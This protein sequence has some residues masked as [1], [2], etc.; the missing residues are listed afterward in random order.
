MGSV[1]ALAGQVGGAK[2]ADGLYRLRQDRLTVVVNTGDDYEHLGLAFSPDLDTMLYTL[3]GMASAVAPWE[4][5]SE[6]HAVHAM[7][8]ALGGPDRPIHGDRSLAAP[9]LR[10]Q[11]LASERSLSQITAA[12]CRNLGIAARVVP[13]SDDRVR[14][15]VETDE[16]NVT[17]QE[18]F[19]ELSCEPA[20]RGFQYAGAEDA[21]MPDA[22]LDALH[23]PDLEAIVICPANPY[24]AIQPILQVSGMKDLL[25]QRRVPVVAVT[26]IVGGRALKGSAGKI[27]RELGREPSARA[28]A[29]QYL[30]LIDGFVL[31]TEDSA[32]VESVRSLGME[33]VALPTIMRTLDDR[34]ALAHEVLDFAANIRVRREAEVE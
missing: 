4:P 25:K 18:Y 24:H 2:L 5:E 10:A 33:V 16:G 17:F 29:A 19:H 31:D 23:A 11:G 15:Y 27:M 6:T 30:R 14:T 32:L 1:V 21:R 7:V 22:L 20:V 13:M 3:A 9:L 34:V 8:K 12:F 28:V 26:P